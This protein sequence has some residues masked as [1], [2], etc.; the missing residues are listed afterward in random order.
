MS[1]TTPSISHHKIRSRPSAAPLQLDSPRTPLSRSVS[2]LYGSPGASFRIDDENLL[3]FE[4]GSR[5]LRAGFAGESAPRCRISYS[6]EIWTRVGDYRRW[7]PAYKRWDPKG[8]SRWADGYEL[9]DLDLRDMD[10]GLVEDRVEKLVREAESKYLLLDNRA[11]RIA[12]TAPSGLPRPLLSIVLRRLFEGLQAA[13]VTILPCSITACIGAGVRSGLVVDVGWFE[14]TVSAVYEYREVRHVRSVRAGKMLNQE[15][16]KMLRRE[17]KKQDAAG[18][19]GIS[20]E[21]VEEVLCRMAWCRSRQASTSSRAEQR[22]VALPINA[23]GATVSQVTLPSTA[24]AEHVESALIA[25]DAQPRQN[26]DHDLPLPQLLYNALLHLP[27][28]IRNLC[29]SHIIFVGGISNVPG[30]KQRILEELQHLIDTRS[31]D[32]I[33][34][35]APRIGF[36]RPTMRTTPLAE[37]KGNARPPSEPAAGKGTELTTVSPPEEPTEPAIPAHARPHDTNSIDAKLALLS[38]KDAIPS[39]LKGEIRAINS[40]G[41]WAG[42]SMVT[43]LRIKGV[44]EVDRDKFMSHGLVGGAIPGSVKPGAT[45]VQ[46]TGYGRPRQSLGANSKLGEKSSTGWNLGVWA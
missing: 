44:I 26:D 16:G 14:T 21:E 1:L 25:S 13:F 33:H 35:Y 24:L 10:L 23:Q 12:L 2:G 37:T 45:M 36:T 30:L 40:L 15:L 41:A 34:E 27:V 18:N 17:L 4:L 42:A 46:D 11:K 9:W 39:V 28:D 19:D 29:I 6:P 22:T 8:K 32:L 7:E 38:L 5:C 3:I 43:N 31:W 20:F